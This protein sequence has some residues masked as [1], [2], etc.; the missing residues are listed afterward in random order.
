MVLTDSCYCRPQLSQVKSPFSPILLFSLSKDSVPRVSMVLEDLWTLENI[1]FQ[2]L[3][4]SAVCSHAQAS[5]NHIRALNYGLH[6]LIT[7]AS[8][9]NVFFP[10]TNY[11]HSK[12]KRKLLILQTWITFSPVQETI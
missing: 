11:V 5:K 10:I 1:D 2:F 12:L 8:Y 6:S 3:I 4:T 9:K 7:R